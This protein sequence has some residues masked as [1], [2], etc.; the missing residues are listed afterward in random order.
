MSTKH[1]VRIRDY[2]FRDGSAEY[3]TLSVRRV[4]HQNAYVAEDDE[5]TL[6]VSYNEPVS[7]FRKSDQAV[8]ETTRKFPTTGNWSGKHYGDSARTRAH[9]NQF[10]Y[11]VAS[12]EE[13]TGEDGYPYKRF[14]S[15][16]IPT[17]HEALQRVARGMR[18]TE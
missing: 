6:L 4:R 17:N 18:T 14:T 8:L 11:H 3:A 13:G 15:P 9:K 10:Y 2:S 16:R 12:F 1:S 7:A 5:Y